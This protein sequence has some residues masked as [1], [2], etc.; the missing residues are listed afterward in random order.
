MS[1]HIDVKDLFDAIGWAESLIVTRLK[2][3]RAVATSRASDPSTF[4]RYVA[5]T[6]DDAVARTILGDLIGAGWTPPSEAMW[7]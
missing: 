6:T 4:P 5:E 7:P 2:V 1:E 3:N